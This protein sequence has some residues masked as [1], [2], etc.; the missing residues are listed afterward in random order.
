MKIAVE[1]MTCGHCVRAITEALR[2]LDPG[3]QVEVDLAGKQV[4]F[5]GNADAASVR[6][7]I[8]EAG[9]VVVSIH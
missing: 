8:V 6:G 7:A 2:G 9:Y 4:D 1:G 5:R 3:A